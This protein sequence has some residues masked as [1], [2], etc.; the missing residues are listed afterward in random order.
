MLPP[1]LNSLLARLLPAFP[2]LSERE[3]QLGITLYRL[4]LGGQPVRLE[5]LAAT[6]GLPTQEIARALDRG[7]RSLVLFDGADRLTGFGGLAVTPTAHRFAVNGSQLFTWCAWDA[8]FIPE[9][10]ATVC[11]VE[12][13]CPQTHRSIHL[14]VAPNR[15]EHVKPA[16]T[17]LSFALPDATLCDCS[18][19]EGIAAFCDHVRF[20]ASRDEG[21]AWVAGQAGLFLMSVSEA[22][23]LGKMF[24]AARYPS[25]SG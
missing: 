4:M 20:L 11:V 21:N 1:T 15:V 6:A 9:L 7:L 18:A 5:S 24:N 23:A 3:Q 16:E 2:E 12:S 22:F 17:V 13:R 14:R 8:L 10:L 25:I 19:S